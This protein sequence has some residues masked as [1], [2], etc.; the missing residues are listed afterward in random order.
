MNRQE[1]FNRVATHLLT[2]MKK[3][4]MGNDG[5]CAYRGRKG[6]AC[7]IGCLITDEAYTPD[8]E[9]KTVNNE[10]VVEAL[11]KCGIEVKKVGYGF[12]CALQKVHDE[13]EY[14]QWRPRLHDV[15]DDYGLTF[16][17]GI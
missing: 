17:E 9:G 1:V 7:A 5:F 6:L 3:S 11:A 2:Q 16:P 13:Y 12:F 15:A 10:K 4:L 8:V 14:Q